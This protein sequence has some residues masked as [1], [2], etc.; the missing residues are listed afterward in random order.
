MSLVVLTAHPIAL[1]ATAVVSLL[2][3]LKHLLTISIQGHKRYIA[4][5]DIL[6]SSGGRR[7]AM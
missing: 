4:G 7:P 2:I 3:L 5:A 1:Q 6:P